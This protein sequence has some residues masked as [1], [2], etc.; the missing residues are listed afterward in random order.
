MSSLAGARGAA[1]ETTATR[2]I[3]A[4][5]EEADIKLTA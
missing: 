3:R 5:F 1:A 4:S 2:R